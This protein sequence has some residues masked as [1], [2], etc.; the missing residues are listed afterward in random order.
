MMDAWTRNLRGVDAG[1]FAAAC[2]ASAESARDAQR[3]MADSHPRYFD[4]RP[5][6]TNVE[7]MRARLWRQNGFHLATVARLLDCST[8]TVRRSTPGVEW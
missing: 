2:V 1:D 7:I 8:D 6:L 5:S 4:D 3:R